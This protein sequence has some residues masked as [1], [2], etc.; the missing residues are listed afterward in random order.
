M[1]GVIS[2]IV[3]VYNV[4]PYLDRC[5]GSLLSQSYPELEI[6]L[7]DDGSTDGSD[8]ICE[9]YARQDSR[10]KLIHKPNGGLASARNA[11]LAVAQGTYVAFVDSD[12]WVLSNHFQ[13]MAEIIAQEQPDIIRTGYQ[14]MLQGT[15]NGQ[16][17]P[18]YQPGLYQGR[19]LRPIRLD[20]I[21]NEFVLDYEKTRILSA[22]AGVFRLGL[23]KEHGLTFQS[24]R[25]ILNEDYLFVLQAILAARSVYFCH[26]AAYCYDTRLDSLSM[27]YRTDMRRRKQ[28]LFHGYC[29]VVVQ[30]DEQER[31]RLRNFYIDCVYDCIVNECNSHKPAGEAIGAIRG[32]LDD[33]ELHHALAVQRAKA[34][35]RKTRC[36]CFLMNHRLATA[37][38]WGY[39]LAKCLQRGGNRA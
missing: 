15:V 12:D 32:L 35:T 39:R 38:Y 17:V 31:G 9:G 3:P 28:N 18:P 22:W 4:K 13:R 14:K 19:A 1:T 29:R 8:E 36:I 2:V 20:T 11:G 5:I 21:S 25:E 10:I 26:D 37:V 34:V 6:I 24:E 23:L 27:V 7:V 30:A 33:S 16:Y